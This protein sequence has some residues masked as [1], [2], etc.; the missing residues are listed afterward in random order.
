MHRVPFLPHSANESYSSDELRMQTQDKDPPLADSRTPHKTP[1]RLWITSTSVLRV[2]SA[3]L[4]A[5][6]IALHIALLLVWSKGLEHRVVFPLDQQRR[7]SLIIT[8]VTTTFGTVYSALLVFVTQTLFMRRS[9]QITKPLTAI[10]DTSAVW[11]GIGSAVLHLW[12]QMTVPALFSVV[13]FN[14]SIIVPVG[15]QHHLPVFNWST[16]AVDD[17]DSV[18]DAYVGGAVYYLPS[19]LGN[20]TSAGLHGGT[21]YDILDANEGVGD[22]QVNATGFNVTCGYPPY[23]K[24]SFRGAAR[25]WLWWGIVV[26]RH[27]DF[28]TEFPTTQPSMIRPVLT[29]RFA[30]NLMIYATIPAVDSNKTHPPSLKLHP[31]TNDSLSN[32]QIM[33]CD[34]TLVPQKVVLEA[35][36]QLV[37][38]VHPDITKAASAWRA[39]TG[40]PSY[41]GEFVPDSTNTSSG[42]LFADLWMHWYTLILFVDF[43]F[44]VLAKA[45]EET[46]ASPDGSSGH[47]YAS[48]LYLLQQLNL[49]GPNA[50]YSPNDT[51]ALHD[52]ENALSR[53][54]AAMFWSTTPF[55]PFVGVESS[56]GSSDDDDI[57]IFQLSPVATNVLPFERGIATVMGTST[58]GRLDSSL[59]A[60]VAG[61][62]ASVLLA[63]LALPSIFFARNKNI[64]IDGAGVLEAI[65]MYRNHPEL[66]VLLPQVEHPSTERLREAGMV[67]TRLVGRW[68]EEP[69]DF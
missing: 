63:L 10:H 34:L 4:H 24:S 54:V 5:V 19:I 35:R 18:L 20:T 32:V 11:T 41:D 65:W 23:M 59:V 67:R 12:L 6:L 37:I 44:S 56:S 30:P 61:L 9:L 3:A 7:V 43:D 36:T 29:E 53:L 27:S 69:G 40:P 8:A 46:G 39:Y 2:F 51:V 47:A 1:A 64:P 25:D 14:T 26:D 15:T 62:V 31:P 38:S 50:T 42:N 68:G 22:V 21:L 16:D 17:I 33:Q 49:H 57:S 52:L 58:L 60:T 66:E 13:T 55:L 45:W 48:D 28:I